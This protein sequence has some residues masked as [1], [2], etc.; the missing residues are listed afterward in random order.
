[1]VYN[2]FVQFEKFRKVCS[3]ESLAFCRHGCLNQSLASNRPWYA[4]CRISSPPSSW[5]RSPLNLTL[6]PVWDR[7]PPF[8]RHGIDPN[9]ILLLAA[10]SW[11]WS[12][13]LDQ[14]PP[15]LDSD[16]PACLPWA[17]CAIYCKSTVSLLWQRQ[18]QWAGKNLRLST[19]CPIQNGSLR[20]TLYILV[21]FVCLSFC[22]LICL[23]VWC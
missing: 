14:S 5:D 15:D 7:F 8:L 4:V 19:T 13:C 6:L 16:P 1:M 22:L 18:L 12:S 11:S 9:L 23:S 17:K 21:F 3:W 10:W 2:Q 20:C